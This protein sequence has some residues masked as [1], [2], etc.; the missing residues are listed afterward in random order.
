MAM[1]P[2]FGP[3][4]FLALTV[5]PGGLGF[6]ALFGHSAFVLSASAIFLLLARKCIVARA[7]LPPRNYLLEFLKLFDRREPRRLVAVS[8]APNPVETDPTRLPADE[9]IAWRETTKR[10]LGQARYLVRIL[11]FSEIPLTI[12]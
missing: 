3:P 1:F 12:F 8:G 9:P 6:G 11:L 5:M 7:F 2:F 4:Y 10:S